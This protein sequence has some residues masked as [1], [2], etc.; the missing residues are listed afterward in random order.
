[1]KRRYLS[2]YESGLGIPTMSGSAA[3]PAS[4]PRPKG[5]DW[6]VLAARLKGGSRAVV[7]LG[8]AVFIA[9]LIGLA[10]R[11]AFSVS[12][13][14]ANAVLVGLA[15]RD[16]RLFCVS[17][18]SAAFFAFIAGDLLFSNS[19]SL[20]MS[21]AACNVIGTAV[22]VSLLR[23][24][25]RR[26]LTLRRVHS[27]L[28]IVSRLLPAS[29][30]A[31]LCG[32]ALVHFQF[33]GSALQAMMTWPASELVNYL[34]VLPAILTLPVP[35]E[36]RD[37]PFARRGSHDWKP[38]LFLAVSCAAMVVFDGPGSIV[39]PLPALLLCALTYSIPST[40][41]MTMVLG[42]WCMTMIGLGYMDIGQ[43]MSIPRMVVSIRVA[44]AF[45][46]LVPLTISSAMEV[47]DSLL[48]QLRKA[49]DHDGLTGLLNR[50]AFEQR[51]GDRLGS[52]GSQ[53]VLWLDIDHFKA[54]ND[55]YGHLAGD[56]VLKS[57]ADTARQCCRATDLVGRMGGEEFALVVEVSS[58]AGAK[59]V[60]ER[61]RDAFARRSVMW[62]DEPVHAT[63]SIGAAH[64]DRGVSNLPELISQ[65]DG[66]LYRA[67]RKGRDRVEWL[68]E[69]DAFD[70]LHAFG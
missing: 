50:R 11:H 58:L 65:L 25:D 62:N 31:G 60:A 59:A 68:A 20:A 12:F 14:P 13:W 55:R 64:V 61:L 70:R 39:F 17:G 52:G 37:T 57:F 45:L 22:A 34:I 49:A 33:H 41:L 7:V 44:V 46:V 53:V 69:S 26:D 1:M 43:D 35:W 16:R 23:L 24:L 63:V 40:T 3:A 48:T 38:G 2:V 67:K 51:M 10:S 4:L 8:C 66:A 54:I 29:L 27:V 36:R 42:T 9:S 6:T 47:R 28:R 32:S 5:H 30:V 15:L 21:F 19:L 18:W 56:A